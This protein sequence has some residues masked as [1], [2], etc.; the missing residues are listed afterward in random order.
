MAQYI[1]TDGTITEISPK[2]GLTFSLQELQ[3]YVGGYI[4]VVSLGKKIMVIDEEGK[5]KE[6]PI[7]T[8]ATK[9]FKEQYPET[10]DVIVG[11]ALICLNKEMK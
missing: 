6:K 1:K 9:K 8:F 3:S 5:L 2:K 7:N 10:T 11:N 4:E